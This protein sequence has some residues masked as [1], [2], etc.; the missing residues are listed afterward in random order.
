MEKPGI[1][2]FDLIYLPEMLSRGLLVVERD[3]P[4]ALLAI[5]QVPDSSQ[6]FKA[7]FKP[8]KGGYDVW[9][10][11]FHRTKPRQTQSILRRGDILQNHS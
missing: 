3:V 1:A 2:L 8:A 10:R 9:L 4:D 7:M 11:T 5:F 6:R